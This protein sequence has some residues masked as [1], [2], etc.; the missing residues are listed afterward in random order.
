M[1]E[2]PRS[3]K[4]KINKGIRN[5]FR[6]KKELNQVAIKYLRS[7]SRQEKETKAIKN[8]QRYEEENY[9]K[10]ARVSNFRSNNYI[11]Y[12]SKVN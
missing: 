10:P 9:Y 12:K 11:Q 3:G 1:M 8:I 6:L 4:E 5:L 7:L 2:N